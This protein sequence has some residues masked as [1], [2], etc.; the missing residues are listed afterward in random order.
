M[1]VLILTIGWL[2]RLALLELVH[3]VWRGSVTEAWV[4]LVLY[5]VPIIILG[6]VGRALRVEHF[7]N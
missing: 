5:L 7:P 1:A 6:V 2:Y 4:T 3:S